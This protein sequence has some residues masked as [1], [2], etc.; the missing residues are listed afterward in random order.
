MVRVISGQFQNDSG[1]STMRVCA[2]R[3]SGG[4]AVVGHAANHRLV[5]SCPQD[6][7][8]LFIAAARKGD[9]GVVKKLLKQSIDAAKLADQ[10]RPTVPPAI[11]TQCIKLC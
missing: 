2:V 11:P 6:N 9:V 7:E 5:G 1:V 3:R 4:A 10:V 8:A